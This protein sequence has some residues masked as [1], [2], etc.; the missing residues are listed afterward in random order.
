MRFIHYYLHLL[1]S[2]TS[3]CAS[4][5]WSP[6]LRPTPRP[7]SSASSSSRSSSAS[8]SSGTDSIQWKGNPD[9]QYLIS[10]TLIQQ[11]RHLQRAALLVLRSLQGGRRGRLRLHHTHHPGHEALP[12]QRCKFNTI[13]WWLKYPK[14]KKIYENCTYC[15]REIVGH[16]QTRD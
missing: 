16:K 14:S 1:L 9:I 11:V 4:P 15:S 7:S 2:P 8:P 10:S 3:S 13:V 6:T 12:S 5:L